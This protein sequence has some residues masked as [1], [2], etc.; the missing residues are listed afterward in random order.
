MHNSLRILCL[1]LA[2]PL[3]AQ[4][5]EFTVDSGHAYA[6]FNIMHKNLAPNYGR[7][8][9][10]KGKVKYE[11][12]GKANAVRI[13]IDPASVDT[14][15]RKRDKHLRSDDYFNVKQFP[16]LVFE[17]QKWTLIKDETY[18]VQGTLNF[19]GVT[20][21]LTA[22]VT[23]TGAGVDRKGNDRIGFTAEFKVDRFAHGMDGGKT[24]AQYVNVVLSI[25]AVAR[26]AQ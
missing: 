9:V 15:N 2:M 22:K 1:L 10:I 7:F 25:E 26:K 17:S 14:A 11:G 21:P 13:E 6:I 12:P 24:L 18:E 5:A 4:A 16:N 23:K 19:H 20:K 3:G 8:N